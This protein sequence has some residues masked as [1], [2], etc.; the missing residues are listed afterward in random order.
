M[1]QES[2]LTLSLVR[3]VL[4][5]IAQQLLVGEKGRGHIP[6]FH[7]K[8]TRYLEIIGH[9]IYFIHISSCKFHNTGF[10]VGFGGLPLRTLEQRSREAGI[11]KVKCAN[12][13][14]M[15]NRRQ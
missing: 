7:L 14:E 3:H 4:L 6:P 15:K 13:K 5:R 8:E 12:A 2:R 11:Q 9:C 1:S 10:L